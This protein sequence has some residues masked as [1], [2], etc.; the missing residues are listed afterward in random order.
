MPE[1]DGIY[2][3]DAVS[4]GEP[5]GGWFIGAFIAEA[6]RRSTAVEVKFSRHEEPYQEEGA[7][8]NRTATSLSINISGACEYR[9]RKQAQG[10]WITVPLTRRGQY[11][12][13]PPGV[14]H[15]LR[16]SECC[17]MVVIRWP[18]AGRSDK[19]PGPDPW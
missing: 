5:Y 1:V 7:T 15:S 4:D 17:E 16:V 2:W 13:W 9:F 18:S 12:I 3:A 10:E 11:V 19:I 14:L 8:A 6:A